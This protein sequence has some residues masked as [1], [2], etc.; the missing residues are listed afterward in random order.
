MVLSGDQ[1][2]RS[3]A[4]FAPGIKDRC[5]EQPVTVELQQ[6]GGTTTWLEGN[7]FVIAGLTRNPGSHG[8][9]VKPGMTALCY[10]AGSNNSIGFPSGSSS[11]V[12]RPGRLPSRCER[13][14]PPS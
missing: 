9:R 12:S 5:A 2:K 14:G 8:C 1:G 3:G 6:V 4:S 7:R 13:A 10:R 11:F